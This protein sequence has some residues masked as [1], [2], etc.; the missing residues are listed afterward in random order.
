MRAS[1]PPRADASPMCAPYPAHPLPCNHGLTQH[2][3]SPSP[4]VQPCVLAHAQ[5]VLTC[6]DARIL[7]HTSTSPHSPSAHA[8]SHVC[9]CPLA[10]RQVR[11]SN[12]IR[13]RSPVCPPAHTRPPAHAHPPLACVHAHPPLTWVH[14]YPP[15][16]RTPTGPTAPASPMPTRRSHARP[17]LP[18]PPAAPMPARRSLAHSPLPH[19]PACPMRLRLSHARLPVPS[20]P[21]VLSCPPVPC[22]PAGPMCTRSL[23][24]SLLPRAPASPMRASSMCACQLKQLPRVHPLAPAPKPVPP[25]TYYSSQ[26]RRHT[27][28]TPL[29]GTDPAHEIGS[30]MEVASAGRRAAGWAV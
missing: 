9:R 1:S 13:T 3:P 12:P 6:P 25:S 11:V 5:P 22:A 30:W 21:P 10:S 24:H 28:S 18:C 14:V 26:S 7:C 4:H 19:A 27:Y 20:C 29:A 15:F 8:S 2:P 16:Q 23:A 17:P